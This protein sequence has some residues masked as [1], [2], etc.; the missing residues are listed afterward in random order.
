MK[1]LCYLLLFCCLVPL[2]TQAQSFEQYTMW[3]QNHYLLNPGAA[4]NL[5]F[6]EAA[7]GYRRQWTGIKEA[8]RSFYASGHTVINRPKTHQLSALRISSTP[9]SKFYNT[10]KNIKPYLKHAI[11]GQMASHQFG[12]FTKT[13]VSGSYA[14]HLP[15][16]DEIYWSFGILAGYNNFSFDET[17]AEVL[18]P[19]DQVYNA[20]AGGQN[21]HQ[22]NANAGTYIYSDRFFFGYSAHHLLQN[23][24]NLA[25]D[26]SINAEAKLI[27]R[28]YIMGGY[29]FDL[30][31]DLRLTPNAL[32]KMKEANP[33]G[34]E[35]GL[36]FTYLDAFALGFN[37]R[38]GDAISLLLGAEINHMFKVGYAFDYTTSK[39]RESASGSHEVFIGFTIF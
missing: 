39:I 22:F 12:A 16:N 8:P 11:G 14:L 25:D 6:F 10:R 21:S 28:H 19:A 9:K 32:L 2:G 1:K 17:K 24:L 15:I 27:M 37:Y 26:E 5:D 3:N 23:E 13:E 4:G 20:Y 29:H 18:N 7:L 33:L 31:N 38:D 35:A 34:I 30:S 36:T